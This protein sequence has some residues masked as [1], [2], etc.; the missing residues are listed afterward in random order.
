VI[1]GKVLKFK[2]FLA[3]RSLGRQTGSSRPSQRKTHKSLPDTDST[4]R[5]RVLVDRSD[6]DADERVVLAAFSKAKRT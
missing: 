6:A 1:A 2:W 4:M 5:R 3:V